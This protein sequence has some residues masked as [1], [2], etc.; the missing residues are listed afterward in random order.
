M[1]GIFDKLA[2]SVR[3]TKIRGGAN[4]GRPN[5]VSEVEIDPEFTT[6]G[7]QDWWLN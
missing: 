4:V 6:I 2:F 3:R 1:V 5:V 7:L